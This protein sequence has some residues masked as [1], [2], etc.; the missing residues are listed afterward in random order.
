MSDK[1]AVLVAMGAG[2]CLLA[3]ILVSRFVTE[4]PISIRGAV[5]AR[6]SDP[7]KQ[8][9]IAGVTI[10]VTGAA[11]TPG[12]QSDAS[13]LFSVTLQKRVRPGMPITIHFRH[14]DYQ[15]LDWKDDA[16][17]KLYVARLTPAARTAPAPLSG[18]DVKISNVVAQYSI[19]T[20][21]AVNVG[22]AVKTFRVDN[23]G[24]V[25]CRGQ[26]PCSPDGRWR[27]VLG[28]TVMDAGPGNEFHNAR[29]SCIAG[30]CPFTRI[31][32]NTFSRDTRNL[33]V[34][35]LDWSDT[36]TFLVEAEVFKPLV[37]D[38]VRQSY[39]LIFGRVLTFILPA[40]AEGVSIQAE[41][42]AA[43]I[44]FPLGPALELSWANCQ[45]VLNPDK[46]KVYR[47]ELKPGYRFS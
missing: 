19:A 38:V 13:G 12:V 15:P 23:A 5:I 24:G 7:A 37:N 17:D 31:G 35:V 41:I 43:L 34:S 25:P 14:P 32:D 9:P 39:P 33:R 20:T 47:C 30:P 22:S 16:V 3:I 29:A 18:P 10:T 8:V 4:N 42:D 21:T 26:R 6:D 40:A 11:P 44:V 36:T 1:K 2:S 46:T 28:S 27:A 45:L